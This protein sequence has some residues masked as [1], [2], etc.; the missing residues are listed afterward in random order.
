MPHTMT[1]LMTRLTTGSI[2]SQFG[3]QDH[4]PSRDDADRHERVGR[5]MQERAAQVDVVL[6][7]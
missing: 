3:Q 5:H 6:A 7:A 4:K 2:Q 1:A